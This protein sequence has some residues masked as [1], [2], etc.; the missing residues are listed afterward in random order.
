[1]TLG[2]EISLAKIDRKWTKSV[3]EEG[4]CNFENITTSDVQVAAGQI[5]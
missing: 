4:V 1:M 3:N 2:S 5:L